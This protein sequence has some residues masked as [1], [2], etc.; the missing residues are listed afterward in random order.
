MFNI[1]EKKTGSFDALRSVLISEEIVNEHTMQICIKFSRLSS[2]HYGK[3]FHPGDDGK[4]QC[5]DIE[6][7]IFRLHI[8]GGDRTYICIEQ[9]TG[10]EGGRKCL[11]CSGTKAFERGL[12]RRGHVRG[13]DRGYERACV[14]RGGG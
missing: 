10:R 4:L 6:G 13:G 12:K 8:H 3:I 1:T 9:E 2:L 11:V 5:Q 7:R 14:G